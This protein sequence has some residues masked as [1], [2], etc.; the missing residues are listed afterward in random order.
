MF[1]DKTKIFV[2]AGDGGDGH[3]SFFTEKYIIKGGPDGGDG[4][5]G[6]DVYFI[7]HKDMSSLVDYNFGVRMAA[8]NG[9]RGASRFSTGKSG[10]DLVIKVPVGTVVRD[11]ETGGILADLTD[12]GQTV[13]ILKGG[14]GGKGNA[15]F[16]SSTR[17]SPYFSQMGQK[18]EQ[19]A[20][21]LELKLIASVGIVGFPNV[22][23]S[24][25]LSTIS[26]AKPK[27][28]NYHF[29][30]LTPSL[31]VVKVYDDV[32]VAAD[33][34]G[35]IEGAAD[36]AGLGIEFLRHIERTRLILHV[37]DISASEG[38]DPLED[39]KII[40]KELKK[41][42]EKLGKLKQVVALNKSEIADPETIKAFKKAVKKPT[43]VISCATRQGLD[44]LNQTVYKVLQ[45]VPK[46]TTPVEL[47][48]YPDRDTMTFEIVR[49]DSGKFEVMGGMID[50]L[51][52]NVVLD[53]IDSNNYFQKKLKDS[54]IINSLKDFGA[55]DGD[56]VQILDIE[57]DYFE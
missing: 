24:T 55:K 52:R 46:D 29:T 16:K 20:I 5:K 45:T 48:S 11:L 42:S 2:K 41:Y 47:Y 21:M 53:D 12:D 56:K 57:F 34:P 10:S 40:N 44:E 30:T 19:K 9:A 39:Y 15:R 32:F 1:V 22:G 8:Q 25:L 33:I 4:G 26:A 54:G 37:V 14:N 31:G 51:A 18:C 17:R 36:G 3:T 6:G 43:V 7:A 23:K 27:I 50:E 35:L 13:M 38:R 49:H 28:G